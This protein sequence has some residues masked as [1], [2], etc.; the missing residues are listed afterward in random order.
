[1]EENND[2]AVIPASYSRQSPRDAV[3]SWWDRV[4]Y[5]P[6]HRAI[7]GFSQRALLEHHQAHHGHRGVREEALRHGEEALAGRRGRGKDIVVV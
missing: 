1:M 6:G 7:R 4:G 2:G 3:S 5:H